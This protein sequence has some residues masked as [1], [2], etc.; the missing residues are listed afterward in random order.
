MSL[1]PTFAR[2]AALMTR[3]GGD[4]ISY[5]HKTGGPPFTIQAVFRQPENGDLSGMDGRGKA[6]VRVEAMIAMV[7]IA[8][9]RP[10]R[11]DLIG[12]GSEK[13]WKVETIEQ[14]AT[15]SFYILGLARQ[16]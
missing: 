8:P 15:E 14:D 13:G 12:L 5:Q 16:D 10:V 2:A 1:R 6:S 7:D 3:V 4:A 9:G 11:G